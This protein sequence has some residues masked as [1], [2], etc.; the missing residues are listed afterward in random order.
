[1]GAVIVVL[2]TAL[3]LSWAARLRDTRK[4][5]VETLKTVSQNTDSYARFARALEARWPKTKRPPEEGPP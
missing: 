2:F 5:L 4:L 3:A 1:M